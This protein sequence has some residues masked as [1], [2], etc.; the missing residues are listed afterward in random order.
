MTAGLSAV[1]LANKWL[2][3]LAGTAFTA[4]A[5][6]WV[7][8][9]VGDPG[10]AGASNASAV[11]T[12]QQVTWSAASGGSKSQASAPTAW[13][14]TTTETITHVSFWDASS[15]GNFLDAA[16]LTTS[17]SVISGDTVTLN[18]LTLAF[19]PIAA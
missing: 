18:T 15:S 9:H 2:D 4:P 3:M 11:V 12:R 16:A 5:A 7:K 13:S 8:L 10:S 17:R 19:T 6:F 1:N 14:M